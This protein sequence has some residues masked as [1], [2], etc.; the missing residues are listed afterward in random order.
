MW[1]GRDPFSQSITIFSGFLHIYIMA[2]PITKLV[3]RLVA[4]KCVETA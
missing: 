2:V 4:E 3:S 1:L